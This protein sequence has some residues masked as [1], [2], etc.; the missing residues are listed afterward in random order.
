LAQI[1]TLQGVK[2]RLNPAANISHI[3]AWLSDAFC[4]MATGGGFAARELH[5]DNEKIIFDVMRPVMLSGICELASR[6]DL[7][8]RS[9][10]IT[11]PTI[12]HKKRTTN[13]HSD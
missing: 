10:S 7:L 4:R 8:D 13:T 3:P 5:S 11:L 12:L 1:S 2:G 6:S 9:I